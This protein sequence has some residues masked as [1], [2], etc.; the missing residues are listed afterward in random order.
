MYEWEPVKGDA[1]QIEIER[2]LKEMESN[3]K[4]TM[5]TVCT[6]NFAAIF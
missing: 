4:C 1:R 5:R 2:Y 6:N 3:V